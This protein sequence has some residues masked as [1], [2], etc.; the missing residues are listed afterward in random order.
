MS[1]RCPFFLKYNS[2]SHKYVHKT[3]EILP[4]LSST[5]FTP[6]RNTTTSLL[7]IIVAI[8]YLVQESP[9]S[10]FGFNRVGGQMSYQDQAVRCTV[11]LFNEKHHALR[12]L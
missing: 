2:T 8:A 4:P 6:H 7:P 1:V 5:K 12:F 9:I 11:S 3:D 10:L